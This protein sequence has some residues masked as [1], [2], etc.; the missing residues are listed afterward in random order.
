MK[1]ANA[2]K[3]RLESNRLCRCDCV[4]G[5]RELPEQSIDLAFAD[6]PFNIGYAY[7]VYD[8]RRCAD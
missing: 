6:P 8:D 3:P 7:D 4:D 5:M 2:A 1:K